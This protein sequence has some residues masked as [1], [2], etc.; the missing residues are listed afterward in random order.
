MNTTYFPRSMLNRLYL[1]TFKV[2]KTSI[3][4]LSQ[5]SK[6]KK[7]SRFQV[8]N[9]G[10]PKSVLYPPHCILMYIMGIIKR[11]VFKD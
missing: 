7:K 4:I 8:R 9:L 5:I 2:I 11:K 10:M 6:K 1:I 3:I